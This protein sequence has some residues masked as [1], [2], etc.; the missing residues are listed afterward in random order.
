MTMTPI[1]VLAN[2][3]A[4]LVAQA[5]LTTVLTNAAYVYGPPGFPDSVVSS[6]PCKL[7]TFLQSGGAPRGFQ[8]PLTNARVEFRCYGTTHIEASLVERTL[9]SVLDKRNNSAI[10][11]NCMFSASK[12]TEASFLTDPS[13]DWP[14]VFVVYDLIFNQTVV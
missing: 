6:M 11:S 2:L 7:I 8:T 10:G 13:T 14:F 9:A 4:Y 1:D 5:T 12:A 3:R